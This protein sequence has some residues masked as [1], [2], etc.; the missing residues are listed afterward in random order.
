MI[1]FDL[2]IGL[3]PSVA[4]LRAISTTSSAISLTWLAPFSL[5]ITGDRA[6]IRYQMDVFNSVAFISR[7]VVNV[8]E[9]SY[10]IPTHRA[11]LENG[12]VYTFT[13]TP[14]NVVGNGTPSSWNFSRIIERKC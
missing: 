9:F 7:D 11:C 6:G 13:V 14:V 12:Y 1:L 10:S 5:A 4:G 8:T 2:F 3:L